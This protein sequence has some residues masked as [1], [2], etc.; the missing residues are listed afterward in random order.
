MR[1][2][3]IIDIDG[4]IADMGKGE[5]GRRGP[6]DWDRVDEDTPVMPVIELVKLFYSAGY[7]IVFVSGRMEAARAGTER[8][9]SALG[10]GNLALYMRADGDFRADTVVKKEIYEK[11][12]RPWHTV[13]YVV[14][15]RNQVVA[16]WRE[17]GLTVLQVAEGDF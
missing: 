10:L 1:G 8:W 2:T 14:D 17:L 13:E 4:T 16:M 15:D 3:A 9:L 6:F 11:E 7:T 12:I 5:P